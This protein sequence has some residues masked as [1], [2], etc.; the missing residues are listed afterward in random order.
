MLVLWFAL[1]AA[2]DPALNIKERLVAASQK[3]GNVAEGLLSVQSDVNRVE[4]ESL[5]KVF[6]LQ[7]LRT[8]FAAHQ[9]LEAENDA[10]KQGAKEFEQRIKDL[11]AA[12]SLVETKAVQDAA[13]AQKALDTV[14]GMSHSLELDKIALNAKVS[15]GEA[16]IGSCNANLTKELASTGAL[17]STI[18]SQAKQIDD[19]TAQ[20]KAM[21]TKAV[22]VE[23]VHLAKMAALG[24]GTKSLEDQLQLQHNYGMECHSK[25]M[26]AQ[27]KLGAAAVDTTGLNAL[28]QA[29][30]AQKSMT[31]D[32]QSR[33]QQLMQEITQKDLELSQVKY[34]S[35][36]EV[37]KLKSTVGNLETSNGAMSDALKKSNAAVF[38]ADNEVQDLKKALLATSTKELEHKVAVLQSEVDHTSEAL[39]L[40]QLEE[41]K[42]KSGLQQAVA[43][44]HAAEETA[45]LNA[46][47]AKKA[48]ALAESEVAKAA[49]RSLA[50]QTTANEA[51]AKAEASLSEQCE[52]TWNEMNAGYNTLKDEHAE[53]IAE[54]KVNKAQVKL[55]AESCQKP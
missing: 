46:E 31:A 14:E 38:K 27:E 37:L 17:K 3:L 20:I 23:K 45:R 36:K 34:Q 11:E 8:F 32:L 2:V 25:L 54:L 39:K 26:Q 5:G 1:A 49:Q 6:D 42:A 7:T 10:L 21:Q 50:A 55:L 51:T 15:E 9:R 48:A 13:A 19:L 18:T 44:Q 43:Y 4:R 47:A 28:Q 33:T 16:A 40:S 35:G 22:E 30:E 52:A 41:A 12:K 29:L 24:A 53:T